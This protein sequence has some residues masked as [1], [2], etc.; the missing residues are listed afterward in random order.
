MTGWPR[1]CSFGFEEAGGRTIWANGLELSMGACIEGGS[2]SS[3]VGATCLV[4]MMGA[5]GTRGFITA[6]R[7]GAL[8]RGARGLGGAAKGLDIGGI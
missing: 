2:W 6:G 1:G 5:V 3:L 8:I 4:S 7:G